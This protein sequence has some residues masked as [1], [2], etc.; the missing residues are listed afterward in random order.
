MNVETQDKTVFNQI[1]RQYMKLTSY[2]AEYQYKIYI[3]SKLIVVTDLFILLLEDD[4][5]YV[6]IKGSQLFTRRQTSEISMDFTS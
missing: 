3:K 1:D 6:G 5:T 4:E 2:N